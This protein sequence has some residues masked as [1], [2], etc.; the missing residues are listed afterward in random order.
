MYQVTSGCCRQIAEHT[1]AKKWINN[2]LKTVRSRHT[3]YKPK[4]GW[5]TPHWLISSPSAVLPFPSR[6]Q[7]SKKTSQNC[8]IHSQPSENQSRIWSLTCLVSQHKNVLKKSRKFTW[9]MIIVQFT[10]LQREDDSPPL[11]RNDS[12][13][14]APFNSHRPELIIQRQS[15]VTD[16]TALQKTTEILIS[17]SSSA[18]RS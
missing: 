5:L 15:C 7:S 10:K 9:K 11:G 12:E 8:S 16:T 18:I 3:T 17:N 4:T 14:I 13:K 2:F 1:S 6:A